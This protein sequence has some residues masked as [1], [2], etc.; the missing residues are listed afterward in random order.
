V[1]DPHRALA[2]AGISEPLLSRATEWLAHEDSVRTTESELAE[3]L[4]IGVADARRVAEAWATAAVVRRETMQR[5]CGPC[6][7]ILDQESIRDGRCSKCSTD[8]EDVPPAAEV[9]YIR[10]R[11]R[12]R[13]VRWLIAVHGIRTDGPWQQELQWLIDTEFSRTVPFRNWKYGRISVTSMSRWTQGQYVR[14]FLDQLR[15]S[16]SEVAPL[17]RVD[18]TPPPD[19][20]AHSFGSWILAHALETDHAARVGHVV[21]VGSIVRPDWDW[22]PVFARGQAT[23]VLN[24]CGGRDLPVKLARFTIHDSGPSGRTGF[25]RRHEQMINVLDPKGTHS[26]AFADGRLADVFRGVWLPFL[27]D[28]KRN[29]DTTSHQIL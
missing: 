24:Y 23:A 19:I 15:R 22:T 4:E 3:H 20:I 11:Q 12:S 5:C 17:L 10:P 29:I 18:P 14:R 7:E 21:L 26:S 9:Q 6:R 13:D 16:Q 27:S 8:L 28:R 2:S 1:T 25:T